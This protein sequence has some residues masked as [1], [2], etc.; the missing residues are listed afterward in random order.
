M[1]GVGTT[2]VFAEPCSLPNTLVDSLT[3]QGIL[4]TS[5]G[6][7]AA[8]L[9][10]YHQEEVSLITT[11]P[12]SRLGRGALLL[13]DRLSVFENLSGSVVRLG[14]GSGRG[15]MPPYFCNSGSWVG[16]VILPGLGFPCCRIRVMALGGW[17]LKV[18][19]E[20]QQRAKEQLYEPF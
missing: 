8:E 5:W 3:G 6:L 9:G 16:L 10:S 13:S 2:G 7:A 18:G 14:R 15:D 11:G 1:R 4:E 17:F 19:L 12:G 20:Q